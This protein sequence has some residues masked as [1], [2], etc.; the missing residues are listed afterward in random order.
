MFNL[1]KNS[2]V[3]CCLA[4]ATSIY[5]ETV[6]MNFTAPE[7]IGKPAGTI[8][9]T[10]TK[11]GLLFTPNLKGMS[12]GIHGF[13]VHINPDCSNNGM[14][15]GGHLDPNHTNKHLGPYNDNGHLGDLPA[16]YV[17]TDGTVTLPVLAPRL[18]HISQIKNHALMVHSG[19]DNYSDSPHPLGG[20]E[21]R[22]VCGIIK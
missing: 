15:A 19:G 12:P 10:E 5:A 17:T 11:Y 9:V 14:A 2:V 1:I 8:Q 6:T 3:L 22:I 7:G 13:H 18:M 16:L 4:G 21:A 20:G